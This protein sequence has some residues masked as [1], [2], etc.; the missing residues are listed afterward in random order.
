SAPVALREKVA[1]SGEQLPDALAHL[2]QAGGFEELCILSTCNRTEI[3]CT[4]PTLD[5][6]RI[7]SWLCDYHEI[8]Q[9]ILYP[10]VYH[11]RAGDAVEHIMKVAA[12]L[13]SMVLGEPQIL[14]QLKDAF[15]VASRSGV[16]GSQL[17][18]LSQN[19]FHVAKK[20]RTETAIGETSVS[21][22]STAVNLA[23]NLF[24]DISECEVLLVGAGDTI[25]LVAKH[26]QQAGIKRFVVANRTLTNAEKLAQSIGGRA[27]DLASLQD[28]LELVDLVFSSTASQLPIMGKGMVERVIKQRKHRPI[29]MVDL[30]VP[31]DIEPEISR[32]PDVYLYTIDDLQS[33]VSKNLNIRQ[34]AA[35]E[36]LQIISES[37]RNYHQHHQSLRAK[38]LLVEFRESHVSLKDQEVERARQRLLKG[39]NA[40]AV[41]ESFASQLLNKMMHQPSITIKEAAASNDLATLHIIRRLFNLENNIPGS[42]TND[43]GET[44]S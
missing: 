5:P 23:G 34:D 25:E 38:D 3:Y 13:D 26:L 12:G 17:N 39:E 28:H 19:T 44:G 37:V 7:V 8:D 29:F 6:D 9:S 24:G 35:D 18:Q 32:L 43:D 22:A 21:V 30:A 41:L 36:A 33:I 2:Q 14:G 42:D 1:F 27:T 11:K 16:I 10:A 4:G 20:I 15:L 31:R 40:D